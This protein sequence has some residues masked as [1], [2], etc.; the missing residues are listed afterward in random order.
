[1][2]STKSSAPSTSWI[3]WFGDAGGAAIAVR[4]QVTEE[5]SQRARQA[6]IALGFDRRFWQDDVSLAHA[7]RSQASNLF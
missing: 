2:P 5:R 4:L 7:A 6:A 1:M 3:L